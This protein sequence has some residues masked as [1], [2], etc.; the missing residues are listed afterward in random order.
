MVVKPL[1]FGMV[2]I[3][4]VV[5]AGTGAYLAVRQN[6]APTPGLAETA[7]LGAEFSD[8]SDATGS[9]IVEA[10]E[11]ILDLAEDEQVIPAADAPVPQTPAVEVSRSAENRV[12]QRREA[13][14][15]PAPAE[16]GADPV[17]TTPSSR[18][19]PPS[20]A[21]VDIPEVDGW[22]RLEE[23]WPSREPAYAPEQV[24]LTAADTSSLGIG[25]DPEERP[26]IIEELVI[27]ADSVVGLQVDTPV[28]TEDAEVEDDVEAR[29]TRD[30]M[31]GDQIARACRNPRDGLGC[32]R[33]ASGEAQGR[34]TPWRPFPY[35][36]HGRWLG[37]ASRH[38]NALS[39]R[40]GTR[41]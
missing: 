25:L 11:E 31:A 18:E 17:A 32:P 36:G 33:R 20:S 12:P 10:T 23:P 6:G 24:V 3:L 28:S 21:A 30:V 13:T 29:V 4:V 19:A 16:P 9:P 34:R 22:T 2:A 38:R 37:G 8:G 15:P 26:R 40:K 27:G 39:R 5:A 7:S 1:A 14:A 35:R 41:R